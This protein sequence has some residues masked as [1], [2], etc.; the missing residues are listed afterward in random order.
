MVAW[1]GQGVHGAVYRAEPRHCAQ[2]LPVALKVA[3][4][5]GD[6]RFAREAEL[7]SRVRHPSVP[8]LWDSGTWQSPAGTLFPWLAME[9]VEGVPLYR[10]GG[11][12]DVSSR[13]CFRV[14]AQLA[15]ALEALHA[16]GAVHRDFKG[17]NVLVRSSDGRAMLTDFGLGSF[18]GAELLTPPGACLGTPL[19]RSPQAGMFEVNS[20]GDGSVR[21]VHQPAD[22]LYALG[23]AACRLLT[24]EYPEWVDPAQDEHGRWRV[25]TVRTPASLRG[26]EPTVRASI[27]RMLAVR[28][29]QR[30]T[31]AEHAEALERASRQPLERTGPR[32]SAR[33][34][35]PW[36]AMTAGLALSVW[37]GWAVSERLAEKPTPAQ[38]RIEVAGPRDAG[39]AGLG[40]AVSSASTA[41]APEPSAPAPLAEDSLP[42]PQPGQLRP[43]ARGRCPR[44]AQVVLNGACWVPFDAAREQCESLGGNGKLFKGRCY[45][46]VLTPE[47]P[48]TSQPTNPP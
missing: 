23:M 35:W 5:P 29:E 13:E 32:G 15:R 12:P 10:W 19:Y 14:L 17:D 36:L 42:E 33:L 34:G 43:D 46:P 20:R 48:S 6:P 1:A 18:P 3:L 30:G 39:T 21:F 11:H 16:Q 4:R 45:V 40:E 37:T 24:G 7:I 27:L 41:Q 9:W 47:R 2:G 25:R 22:D 26:V 28:P 38:V 31:A 8:R 44:K